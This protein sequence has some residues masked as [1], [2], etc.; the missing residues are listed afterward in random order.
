V[1]RECKQ[2]L[3]LEPEE[4]CGGGRVGGRGGGRVTA[5]TA[6]AVPSTLPPLH[7]PISHCLDRGGRLQIGVARSRYP[8]RR[9]LMVSNRRR[10]NRRRPSL[11]DWELIALPLSLVAVFV[12]IPGF[13][14]VILAVEA[15]ECE[16]SD[17][18]GNESESPTEE[19][20]DFAESD[21][22]R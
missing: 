11:G 18:D 14:R 3:R 21:A 22:P 1:R 19:P 16:L 12:A 17:T 2:S 8:L 7:P 10:A 13:S 15:Q 6:V 9:P 5:F 20:G 4:C